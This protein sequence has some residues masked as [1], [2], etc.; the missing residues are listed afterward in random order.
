MLLPERYPDLISSDQIQGIIDQAA[1]ELA[2]M[3]QAVVS[4]SISSI[5]NVIQVLIYLV[6]VPI[7]VFFF[8]KDGGVIMRWWT[9]FLP[10]KRAILSTRMRMVGPPGPGSLS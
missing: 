3:G 10:E 4:F 1:T 6:L 8:M 5:G 2:K 9:G 7:L